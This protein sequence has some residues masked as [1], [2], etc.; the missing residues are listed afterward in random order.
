M[1]MRSLTFCVLA[2]AIVTGCEQSSPTASSSTPTPV[3]APTPA[4]APALVELPGSPLQGPIETSV[5]YT[6]TFGSSF[7]L[8][9]VFSVSTY[10][11]L[12]Q[13][14]KDGRSY[15]WAGG[16]TGYW[17]EADIVPGT[18]KITISRQAN[19]PGASRSYSLSLYDKK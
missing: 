18:Y 3:P 9:A 2:V 17:Y 11:M 5:S 19:A 10:Y 12:L 14:E 15:P 6:R 4:P 1:T 7:R 13:L 8:R 16:E